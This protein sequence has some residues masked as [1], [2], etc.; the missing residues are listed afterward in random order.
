MA[1]YIS[2]IFDDKP[3]QWGLRGDPDFWN[4]LKNRFVSTQLPYSE[5]D[6]KQEIAEEFRLLTG[7]YPDEGNTYFV[8]S[9]AA[10]Y[11]G[12][13]T[14]RLSGEFWVTRAIPLLIKRLRDINS[15]ME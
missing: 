4:Y 3:K 13:S 8:E 15:Q 2:E 11:K 5:E 14:G 12:M 1:R 7:S 9:F 10:V 6:F